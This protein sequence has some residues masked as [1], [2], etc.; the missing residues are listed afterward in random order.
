M[1]HHIGSGWITF[2]CTVSGTVFISGILDLFDVMCEQHHRN[3]FNPFLNGERNG[4]KNVTCKPGLNVNRTV[5][6]QIMSLKQMDVQFSN[7]Q[8]AF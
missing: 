4:V 6:L 8:V 3:S 1:S 2:T 7:R 5:D